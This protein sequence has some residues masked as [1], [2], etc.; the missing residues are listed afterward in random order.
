MDHDN[1]E[2]IDRLYQKHV[3]E[4]MLNSERWVRMAEMEAARV[5]MSKEKPVPERPQTFGAWS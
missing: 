5:A 1:K 3:R 2:V 4:A